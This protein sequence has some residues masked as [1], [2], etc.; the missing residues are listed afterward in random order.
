MGTKMT[1]N[2]IDVAK[3]II[4]G[5]LDIAADELINT[6]LEICYKCEAYNQFLNNC[7]VCGC[8]LKFKTPLLKSECPWEKW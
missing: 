4:T 6:R 8:F 3:D 1:Y 2:I 5:D 7:T